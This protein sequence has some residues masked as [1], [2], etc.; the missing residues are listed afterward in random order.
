MK[1]LYQKWTKSRSKGDKRNA[2][3]PGSA[4]ESEYGDRNGAHTPPSSSRDVSG[5]VRTSDAAAHTRNSRGSIDASSKPAFSKV[6]L[7]FCSC[8][9][10]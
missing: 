5:D 3:G 4:A 2:K 10:K 9:G 7:L 6:V 1:S 8:G